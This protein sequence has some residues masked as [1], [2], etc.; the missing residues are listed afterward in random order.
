MASGGGLDPLH[1]A[2]ILN[3]RHSRMVLTLF[4]RV[5]TTEEQVV[6]VSG[7]RVGAN[8]R[9]VLKL[10]MPPHLAISFVE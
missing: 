10:Q 1:V 9:E 3:V 7:L 2:I 5:V 4:W 8:C 6:I